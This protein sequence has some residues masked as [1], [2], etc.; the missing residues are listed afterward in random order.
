MRK[1]EKGLESLAWAIE[2]LRRYRK[3]HEAV[4]RLQDSLDALGFETKTGLKPVLCHEHRTDTGWHLVFH[5][6]PGISSREIQ[7]KSEH[8][9]EQA[10][11]EIDFRLIGQKLHMDLSLTELARDIPY[12]RAE[13]GYPDMHLPVPL[14][15]TRQGPLV[16][17]LT[18]GPHML[19]GGNTGNGKTTFLRGLVVSLLLASA[20]VVIVD[21]K[22]GLD[23]ACFRGHCRVV[24]TDNDALGLMRALQKECQ[25]RLPILEKASVTSLREYKGE[26]LPWIVLVIDEVAEMESKEAQLALNRLARLSRSAGVCIV[27][28]TQRPSANIFSTSTFSNTRMLL[29]MRLCFSVPKAEDSKMVLDDDAAAKIPPEI[30]GRAIWQWD[31]QREVQCYNLSLKGARDILQS[32]PEKEVLW[33]ERRGKKLPPRPENP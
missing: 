24:T 25:R 19:M 11:G 21:L 7:R 16:V 5:L 1:E 13:E 6:P 32:I 29:A 14:G 2:H 20:E 9:E 4:G 30:K 15:I 17:D 33:G 26:D 27:C 28:A 18:E 22:G 31:R 12:S 8:L 10:G 3:G 23:F